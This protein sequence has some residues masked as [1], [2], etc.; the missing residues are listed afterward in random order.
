MNQIQKRNIVVLAMAGLTAG[1][2]GCGGSTPAPAP[3]AAEASE[4]SGDKNG[5]KGEGTDKH[6]CNGEM[7]KDDMKGGGDAMPAGSAA[8]PEKPMP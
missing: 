5:C 6:S 3:A 8:P 7:K 4:P 1:L 2:A